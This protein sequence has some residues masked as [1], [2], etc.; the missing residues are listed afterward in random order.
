MAVSHSGVDP[1]TPSEP[2]SHSSGKVAKRKRWASTLFSV[3]KLSVDP[4][5]VFCPHVM[6]SMLQCHTTTKNK[7]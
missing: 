2:P 7:H 1:T 3:D 6:V 4:S 5:S